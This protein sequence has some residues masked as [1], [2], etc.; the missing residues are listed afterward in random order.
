MRAPHE[1]TLP[2]STRVACGSVGHASNTSR[3]GDR[4]EARLASPTVLDWRPIFPAESVVTGHVVFA[5][6]A[7]KVTGRG[8]LAVRFEALRA[9]RDR[10]RN[11]VATRTCGT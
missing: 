11:D 3:V 6:P 2:A 1:V 10:E 8:S 5:R 7:G 4:V 9:G